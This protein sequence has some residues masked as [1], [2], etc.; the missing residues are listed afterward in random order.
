MFVVPEF[1]LTFPDFLT[2][3]LEFLPLAAGFFGLFGNKENKTEKARRRHVKGTTLP[4][5]KDR[6]FYDADRMEAK[7]AEIGGAVDPGD[8]SWAGDKGKLFSDL[9]TNFYDSAAF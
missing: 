8:F 9:E 7:E 5:W 1:F 2:F 4:Y 3:G 6:G